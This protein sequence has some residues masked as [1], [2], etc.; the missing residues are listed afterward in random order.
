MFNE[1]QKQQWRENRHLS[2]G[3]VIERLP[4]DVKPYAAIVGSWVWLDFP[5]KPSRAILDAVKP[6]GFKWNKER[7]VWQHP[8]GE[9]RP[10]NPRRDPRLK[11]GQVPLSAI[12][13]EKRAVA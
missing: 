5:E 10:F 7:K 12:D 4:D 2:T 9:F 3:Q 1:S 6:L 11:Y 8:C 13:D